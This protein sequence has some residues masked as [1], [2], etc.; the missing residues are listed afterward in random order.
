MGKIISKILGLILVAVQLIASVVL[1]GLLYVS[2]LLPID[3][4][5][6]IM[7]VL[8]VLVLINLILQKWIIGGLIGKLLAII[9]IAAACLG[10]Y[11]L[12]HTN[13]AISNITG[14]FIQVDTMEFEVLA[15]D[16]AESLEDA[17]DYTFGILSSMDRANTDYAIEDA[18]EMLG[19]S[20][21][22]QEYDDLLSLVDAL[23]SGEVGGI[24]LNRA[25]IGVIED[26]EEY[27]GF[28]SDIKVLKM[29][30]KESEI[31]SSEEILDD[32]IVTEPFSVYITGYDQTGEV[33]TKGR[34]DVNIIATVNPVTKQVLLVSTPR[35]YYIPLS[36]SGDMSDKLTHAGIYGVDVSMDSLSMLYDTDLSL[37][38]KVNF[39]GFQDI[40]DALGGITV[41][42]DVA[43]TAGKDATSASNADW[44]TYDYV[45]G[46]NELDGAA[47]LAFA[48]ERKA[49]AAGDRQRGA[50]Q[51]RVIEGVLKKAQSAALLKNYAQIMKSI[52]N[53][54][55][56][57]LSSQQ[58]QALVQMQI[59][60]PAEWNIKTYSVTGSDAKEYTYSNQ[61]SRSYVMI[62]DEETVNKAI[63]LMNLVKSG[64]IITDEDL[65]LSD[66][67]D[68]AEET[69]EVEM[70]EY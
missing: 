7:L 63:E 2:N 35:D 67:T 60:D 37:Y 55:D 17:R 57:N 51:M 61:R 50:N 29:V 64:V 53:S 52:S 8:L 19:S 31:V 15:D 49:F 48:R 16:P 70:T 25:Y 69:G 30:N 59:S 44:D 18:E 9:I 65:E 68:E 23:Y 45:E 14:G 54:F 6:I 34:S 21:A 22:V 26:T 56:S 41:V 46:E 58:I 11:M 28:E 36:I 1:C 10:S 42:S 12:A 20:L 32:K 62:P 5:L 27:E 3:S 38:F 33:S 43:F 39:S 66:E 47:A 40:I 13:S 24:I 4:L